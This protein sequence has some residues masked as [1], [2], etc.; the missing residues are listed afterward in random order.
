MDL[1]I[2]IGLASISDIPAL[3]S[4]INSAYRGEESKKGW[5]TEAFIIDG[6]VRIDEE[7]LKE[8][9]N[10]PDADIIIYK[11]KDAVIEGSVYLQ[12]KENKLYLGMLS[13]YPS[14][15]AKGIGKQLLKAAENYAIHKNCNAIF[16]NVIS[17]RNELI[18][19]YE[20]HGYINTEVKSPFPSDERFG[21]PTIPLE[22]IILEKTIVPG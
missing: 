20:R 7:A 3:V 9:I 6:T 1:N 11:N 8:I 5:T 17:I 18:A 13:V 10:Q 2:N 19:W 12:K 15:Q 21:I 22:F 4:L 14:V 16:M